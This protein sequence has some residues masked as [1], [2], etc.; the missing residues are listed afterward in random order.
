MASA[1]AWRQTV[2]LRKIARIGSRIR[3]QPVLADGRGLYR[4]RPRRRL[5]YRPEWRPR[6]EVPIDGTVTRPI[7][8]RSRRRALGIAEATEQQFAEVDE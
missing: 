5:L 8:F 7:L 6:L 3:Y 2:G 4:V 1:V